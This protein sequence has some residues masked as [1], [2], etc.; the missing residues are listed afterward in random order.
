MP[1]LVN[2]TNQSYRQDISYVLWYMQRAPAGSTIEQRYAYAM[3]LYRAGHG[4]AADFPNRTPAQQAVIG[5]IARQAY[6]VSSQVGTAADTD[7][8]GR[9]VAREQA[10]RNA[11]Y[12]LRVLVTVEDANG[13][14]RE[15]S[16]LWNARGTSTI[17]QIKDEI[18]SYLD[19]NQ[20]TNAFHQRY[21]V[22]VAGGDSIQIIQTM[23]YGVDQ[24]LN[25]QVQ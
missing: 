4:S 8:L 22:H 11:V 20:I 24:P 7:R 23:P 15:I 5:R 13:N 14:Q 3:G 17:G 6:R 9:I 10:A 2:L 19:A 1:P 21:A 18:A 12:G 16:V 25:P